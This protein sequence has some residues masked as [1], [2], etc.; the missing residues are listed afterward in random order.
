MS[1]PPLVVYTKSDC[2]RCAQLKQW[3]H[4]HHIPYREKSLDRQ[5]VQFELLH[6]ASF[7]D[8]HCHSNPCKLF[9]PIMYL[10]DRNEYFQNKLFN[11]QGIR[12]VF[13]QKLLLT[14]DS[15]Q[16]T[17]HLSEIS[18]VSK[19]SP[20]F[21]R[22]S[23]V[24]NLLRQYILALGISRIGGDMLYC[25]QIDKSLK[26]DLISQFVAALSMFGEENLGKI[27]RIMI[28]GLEIE[29]SV[30][31]RHELVFFTMFRPH[32]TQDYLDEE[33]E[34]TLVKFYRKYKSLLDANRSNR[35][36]F[37]GFDSDMC[38]SIQEYL[39][40]V[41]ILECVDCTLEIPLLRQIT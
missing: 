27:D 18:R 36:L 23:I 2:H 31:T 37:E 29:M 1:A 30:V 28:K 14:Q 7:V 4:T 32:M 40:R 34:K 33:S 26:L 22:N 16:K 20:K 17:S 5:E 39:V 13:L 11:L 3:M 35:A 19:I 15:T 41:G 12:T 8:H 24:E 9:P 25:I 10:P 6:D 21:C 38:L